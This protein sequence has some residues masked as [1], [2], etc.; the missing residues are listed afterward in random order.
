[1][2]RSFKV[3]DVELASQVLDWGQVEEVKEVLLAR[4]TLFISEHAVTLAN[5][6]GRFSPKN[7]KSMFYGRNMQLAKSLL[8]VDG[9][10]LFDGF[11]K[12]IDVDHANRTVT[13]TSQNS[14]TLPANSK[15]LLTTTG[16]P[17]AIIRTILESAGLAGYL[18]T[19]S[20]LGAQGGSSGA[21]ATIGVNYTATS[22]ATALQAIQDI[23][24]L[25]SL[26][27]FV[28]G[29]LIRLREF[30]PY[31]GSSSGIKYAVTSTTAYDFGILADAPNNIS[32]SVT[33]LYGASSSVTLSDPDAIK[34]NGGLA[35]LTT[36]A[37]STNLNLYLSDV[38]SA[39]YFGNL[40]LTRAANLK[41]IGKFRAGVKLL[42]AHIGDRIT[43]QADN[44]S[45][46]P[47]A[48]E[49][50]EVRR[51]IASDSVELVCATL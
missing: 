20:F 17:A 40:F 11:I 25:C 41:Q 27:C 34:A 6:D 1:M 9:T 50:I 39:R 23:S 36:F 45:T 26:S 13:I 46:S 16:N 28:Q 33:V 29:G 12:S 24:A 4:A 38:A 22:N 5:A 32:N 30:S 47:I 44:W 14:L 2:P 31:Q 37:T 7:T 19:G 8:S 48:F 43:V 51:A 3:F 21:G 42:D 49:I 18:D 10:T 15:V 35:V